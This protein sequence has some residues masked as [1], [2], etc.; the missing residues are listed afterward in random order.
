MIPKTKLARN[1]IIGET[2]AKVGFKKVKSVAKGAFLSKEKRKHE[3]E[4]TKQEI[5][6]TI[7][8]GLCKLRGTALKIAQLFCG[9]TGI[10]PESYMKVFEQSHYK[11]P[12]LNQAVIRKVIKQEL[13]DVPENIFLEF[14]PQAFAAASLGQVH[15]AVTKSGATVAVKIQYPGIDTSVVNDFELAK[16][17][18]SPLPN[19]ELL[20]RTFAEL[21]ERLLQEINYRHEIE[22]TFFFQ[23]LNINKN[24]IIPD[25]HADLSTAYVL[26]TEFL[27]GV[28]VDEWLKTEPSKQQIDFVAQNLFD[29]FKVS[30]FD[31]H[32]CH[33]DP[34]FGN[35]LILDNNALGIIDFGAVKKL[36]T[37]DVNL[38]DLLWTY[39]KHKDKNLLLL[40]YERRGANIEPGGYEKNLEFFDRI[41]A[42]YCDW[43]GE[44][45]RNKTYS[46]GNDSTYIKRGYQLFSGE[47]FN[48]RLQNFSTDFTLLHRTL[49]GLFVAFTRM[50]ATVRLSD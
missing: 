49:H 8:D 42:P 17:A 36:K 16:K 1:K 33:A 40:E 38:Y 35:F 30:V 24:I 41:I 27:D 46:F 22:N 10:L 25:C 28:H 26:T 29:F 7:F 12:P 39:H 23:K 20:T 45:L 18:L 11:V 47:L 31:H 13:G 19:K 2:A 32:V 44:A 4:K 43:I 5:A 48:S 14:E 50:K 3:Q 21:E 37:D 34:N 9:E 15:R 6:E